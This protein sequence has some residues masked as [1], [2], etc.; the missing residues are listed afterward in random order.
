MPLFGLLLI[1]I[2][3]LPVETAYAVE[4]HAKMAPQVNVKPRTKNVRY[5]FTK[6]KAELN[7]FDVDTISPYGPNHR[8]IVSGLMSGSIQTKSQV[9][10]M[11]E[12]YEHLDRGC[13]YLKAAN[14]TISIDPTIY[15][16][17]EY[18]KGSCYH[19]A[20]LNHERKHVREDQLI[21]NK[22]VGRIGRALKDMIDSQNAA[23]GPYRID[24]MDQVQINIQNS[25][26]KV[27]KRF[28]DDMNQERRR[29][30]QAIDNIEEY[31][32]IGARCPK[33]RG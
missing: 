10:F 17:N 14:V 6:S 7:S 2:T 22:Y 29:R 24:Q 33:E 28:N 1:L 19:N 27:V 4:C 25:I 8:T 3:F 32:S 9:E 12:K 20:V 31:E 15:V 30:Q 18:P 21:V 26:N 13:V 16:A 11:H 5:D 23:F